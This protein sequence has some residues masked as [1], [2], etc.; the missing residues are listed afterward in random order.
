MKKGT[1]LPSSTVD[2]IVQCAAREFGNVS[3][4]EVPHKHRKYTLVYT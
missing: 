4:E 1:T 2:G 3:L